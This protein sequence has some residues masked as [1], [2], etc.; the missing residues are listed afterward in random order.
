ML[1]PSPSW[2]SQR[3]FN[4]MVELDDWHFSPQF[5][6]DISWHSTKKIKTRPVIYYSLDWLLLVLQEGEDVHASNPCNP[7]VMETE[8]QL[9]IDRFMNP[10][11]PNTTICFYC[12]ITAVCAREIVL[13]EQRVLRQRG[14]ALRGAGGNSETLVPYVSF[15]FTKRCPPFHAEFNGRRSVMLSLWVYFLL[16]SMPTDR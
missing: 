6:K 3:P 2:S 11:T 4:C 7:L 5:M 10:E 16:L 13:P 14:S 9:G 15:T 1:S 8:W 12:S